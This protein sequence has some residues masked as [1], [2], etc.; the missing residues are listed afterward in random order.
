MTPEFDFG[1]RRTLSV[2]ATCEALGVSRAKVY[3]YIAA[4]LVDFVRTPGGMIRIFADSLAHIDR[5]RIDKLKSAIVARRE[6]P[7]S[8]LAA[9]PRDGPAPD[10]ILRDPF[11]DEPLFRWL[12]RS[13]VVRNAGRPVDRICPCCASQLAV[14]NMYDGSEQEYETDDRI[15]CLLCGWICRYEC[16]PLTRQGARQF[17]VVQTLRSFSTTPPRLRQLERRLRQSDGLSPRRHIEA[18]VADVF[19]NRDVCIIAGESG[20]GADVV[21][22]VRHGGAPVV[23]H[24]RYGRGK[25]KV[26]VAAVSSLRSVNIDWATSTMRLNVSARTIAGRLVSAAPTTHDVG[27][28]IASGRELLE[29]VSVCSPVQPRL[30]ML[31]SE[32]RDE[33]VARRRVDGGRYRLRLPWHTMYDGEEDSA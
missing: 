9:R 21:T 15:V 24:W 20:R 3:G 8:P 27:V 22:A 19:R 5:R 10:P 7:Q 32:I 26:A 33:I 17:Y 14:E 18:V 1:S 4:G 2:M 25:E 13:R 30:E 23:L 31:T 11:R 16:R 12:G 6:R 29:F 28:D